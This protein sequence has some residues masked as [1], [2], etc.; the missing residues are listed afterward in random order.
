MKRNSHIGNR[1]FVACA[2]G[3]RL[4]SIDVRTA[5]RAPV[6]KNSFQI[7]LS[8]GCDFRDFCPSVFRKNDLEF[9]ALRNFSRENSA[10]QNSKI[11]DT[12]RRGRICA[13]QHL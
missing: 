10:A 1:R 4:L 13:N 11:K 5:R 3:A 2:A 9:N 8:A 6:S 12:S 7:S